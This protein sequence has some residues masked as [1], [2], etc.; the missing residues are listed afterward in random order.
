[1]DLNYHALDL[2][3]LIINTWKSRVTSTLS[4]FAIKTLVLIER[5]KGDL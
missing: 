2:N 3:Y 1:M 5:Q 4:F